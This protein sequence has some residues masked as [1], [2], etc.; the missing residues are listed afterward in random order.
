M[1]LSKWLDPKDYDE[2]DL[3]EPL[4]IVDAIGLGEQASEHRRWEYAVALAALSRL[5]GLAF[6]HFLDVG[7]AGSRFCQMAR[8]LGWYGLLID[9]KQNV[10]LATYRKSGAPLDSAVVCLSV[11]EHIPKTQYEAF[12]ADLIAFVRPSGLLILTMDATCHFLHWMRE[13]IY[14]PVTWAALR[15]DILARGFTDLA[16]F[17]PT[18]HPPAVYDYSF[19]SLC[20]RRNPR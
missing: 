8:E 5:P 2:P 9:P 18:V 3:A 12:L 16:G 19:A 1:I 14:T 6:K 4:K 15:D 17:D 10:D 13:R 7:G 11:L 20:F